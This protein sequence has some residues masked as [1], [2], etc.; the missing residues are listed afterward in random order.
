[1]RPQREELLQAA[2]GREIDLVL[3]GGGLLA[4]KRDHHMNS[5]ISPHVLGATRQV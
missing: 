4:L 2:R 3:V 5:K 1:M